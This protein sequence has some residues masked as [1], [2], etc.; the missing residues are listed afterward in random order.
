PRPPP[1]PERASLSLDF[2]PFPSLLNANTERSLPPAPPLMASRRPVPP[3][4]LASAPPTSSRRPQRQRTEAPVPVLEFDAPKKTVTGDA[5]WSS[6]R[7]GDPALFEQS[8]PATP[9]G[10]AALV[11]GAQPIE[12]DERR[13][14]SRAMAPANRAKLPAPRVRIA[15]VL[16]VVIGAL[17]LAAG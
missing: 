3:R 5:Y 17:G 1:V 15:A 7:S 14:V 16:A 13:Q 6:R 11:P 12:A 4:P 2:G 8:A 9:A 10:G